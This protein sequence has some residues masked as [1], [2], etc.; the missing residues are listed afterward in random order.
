[1]ANSLDLPVFDVCFECFHQ[2]F[3]CVFGPLGK[4]TSTPV[5]YFHWSL[6]STLEWIFLNQNLLS[7]ALGYKCMVED[8]FGVVLDLK[9]FGSLLGLDEVSEHFPLYAIVLVLF[10]GVTGHEGES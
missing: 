1:M 9:Q 3:L 2:N 10:E 4:H 7:A 6:I 8:W 5:K